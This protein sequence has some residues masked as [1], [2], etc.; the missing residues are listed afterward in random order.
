MPEQEPLGPR[1]GAISIYQS[2]VSVA[3]PTVD[4]PA[5][6]R[7]L[8]AFVKHLDD[9]GFFTQRDPSVE[10]RFPIIA[11]SHWLARRGDLE[12][13]LETGGRIAHV[14]FFQKTTNAQQQGGRYDFRK[15]D[16]MPAPMKRACVVEMA[17]LVR[18]LRS[19]GYGFPPCAA[20][21]KDLL[22]SI[23]R[24][25]EERQPDDP[26]E[27]FNAHWGANRFR[28]D[29]T[30]WPTAAELG[31]W[32]DGDGAEILNGSVRYFVH[33][34]RL[35]CSTVHGNMNGMWMILTGD[36]LRYV[37]GEELFSSPD[38]WRG[39]R[40]QDQPRRLMREL[41][42]ETKAGRWGRVAAIAK[43]LDRLASK[44]QQEE[45]PHG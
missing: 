14:E 22:L 20:D 33:H 19:L 40:H 9:R 21:G 43:V 44:A 13:T 30:G 26:L 41:D 36:G 24:L 39:R 23:L 11:D 45:V 8:Q 10:K 42:K 4:E 3:E 29:A 7:V 1:R 18:L 28:R 2:R 34:G 37:Q 16:A 15:F 31:T 5:M 35:Q 6:L 17:G 25:A 27:R 12:A 32:L 38:V